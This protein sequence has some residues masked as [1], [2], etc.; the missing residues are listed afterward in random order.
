VL[1]H[2]NGK[3]VTI[4]MS[5]RR[6]IIEFTQETPTNKKALARRLFEPDFIWSF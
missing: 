3:I 4:N 6:F 1:S 2:V 5:Q